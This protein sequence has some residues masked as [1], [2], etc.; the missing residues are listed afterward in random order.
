MMSY[1]LVQ[2]LQ[3]LQSSELII[4]L[5]GEKELIWRYRKVICNSTYALIKTLKKPLQIASSATRSRVAEE[6]G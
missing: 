3:A 1:F 5:S 6:A 4:Y 2:I